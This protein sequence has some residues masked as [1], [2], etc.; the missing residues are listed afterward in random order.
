MSSFLAMQVTS[1]GFLSQI[2]A[3]RLPRPYCTQFRFFQKLWYTDKDLFNSHKDD[4]RRW[5][6]I[7]L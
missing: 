2:E 5:Q 1:L 6:N 7:T 4:P 3:R